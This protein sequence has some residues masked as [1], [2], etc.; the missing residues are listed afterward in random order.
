M[1]DKAND[2]CSFLVFRAHLGDDRER[3]DAVAVEI[4]DY[5]RWF[6]FRAFSFFRNVFIGL[7]E[8]DLY[9]ELA[10]DFLDLGH[11]E[12]VIDKGKNLCWSVDALGERFH[13]GSGL[14]AIVEP[15]SL[16]A[17][18][19]SLIAIAVVHR[20]DKTRPA[21]TLSTPA[22]VA[23]LAVLAAGTSLVAGSILAILVVLTL[24]LRAKVPSASPGLAITLTLRILRLVQSFIHSY[25]CE[26]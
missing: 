21:A 12:K 6:L 24:I 5:Q 26:L 23:V 3:L 19:I 13:I 1:G 10:G 15:R 18:A 7:D 17:V 25:T 11:E 2:R 22:I 16:H 8:F 4:D 14:S 20:A 9:I